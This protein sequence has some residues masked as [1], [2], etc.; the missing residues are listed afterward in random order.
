LI[1]GPDQDP[2]SHDRVARFGCGILVG[3]VMVVGTLLGSSFY[4]LLG[5]WLE[6]SQAFVWL[7]AAGL[8]I[9]LGVASMVFG[10]RLP[11]TLAKWMLG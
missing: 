2:E 8:P 10:W 1:E 3:L 5:P 4:G 6:R 9:L 7:F 11:E